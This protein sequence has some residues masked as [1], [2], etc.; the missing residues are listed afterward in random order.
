MLA[1]IGHW[2]GADR[3]CHET[4]ISELNLRKDLENS[5]HNCSQS[6]VSG[7]TC[8]MAVYIVSRAKH[9]VSNSKKEQS[10]RLRA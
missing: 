9:L 7:I 2:P 1:S 10:S 5:I 4:A 8:L 3:L 6:M